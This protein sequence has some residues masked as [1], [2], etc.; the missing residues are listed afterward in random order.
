MYVAVHLSTNVVVII[1]EDP[2]VT[3][4]A[5]VLTHPIVQAF[6]TVRR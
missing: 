5:T 2:I 4:Y 1:T 6:V 3:I